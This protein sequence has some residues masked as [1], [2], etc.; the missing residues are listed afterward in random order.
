MTTP[1]PGT[2]PDGYPRNHRRYLRNRTLRNL[3]YKAAEG[4]CAL[5]GKPLPANWHAD[6]V[7]PWVRSRRTNVLGMQATCPTCNARKGAR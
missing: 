1:E 7:E 2:T 6:H 4:R 3:L 5:C